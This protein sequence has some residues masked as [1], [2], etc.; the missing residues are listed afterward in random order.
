MFQLQNNIKVRQNESTKGCFKLNQG[1]LNFLEQEKKNILGITK[2]SYKLELEQESLITLFALFCRTIAKHP[3]QEGEGGGGRVVLLDCCPTQFLKILSQKLFG[4]PWGKLEMKLFKQDI[5]FRFTCCES[6]L[7]QN[8]VNFQ[9]IT[10][11]IV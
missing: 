1:L 8:F 3:F 9:S 2:K 5:K 6:T 4:S 7:Y 10:N 11:R